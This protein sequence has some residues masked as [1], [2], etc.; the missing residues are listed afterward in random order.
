MKLVDNMLDRLD[1]YQRRHRW[2]AFLFAVV[3]KFGDDKAGYLAA[4][5]TYYT[6]FSLFLL[7]IVFVTILGFVLHGNPKLTTSIQHSILGQ[8]PVIGKQIK[9]HSLTGS[10]VALAVALL[11]TLWSGLG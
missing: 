3:K 5:I 7:L 9:V 1:A 10:G 8:F 2:A 11:G 4:L 6:F